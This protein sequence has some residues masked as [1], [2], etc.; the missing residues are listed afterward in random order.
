MKFSLS[1]LMVFVLLG[2][3]SDRPVSPDAAAPSAAGN[4]AIIRNPIADRNGG[5]TDTL[6]V[7]RFA[8]EE[9]EYHFGEV[10]A[11]HK[12]RHAFTFTNVGDVPLLI[13]DARSTCGC[14]IPDYPRQPIPPGETGRVQVE[15]STDNK[16]GHQRKPV[17]L[18][19]NTLPAQ[20]TLYLTGT[21]R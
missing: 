8:F 7:A 6:H 13:T 1:G 11:G 17:T 3:G 15:F 19:A 14:T 18:S 4:A 21:V 12:V 16:R 2:C 20:T 9:N 5:A 10:T